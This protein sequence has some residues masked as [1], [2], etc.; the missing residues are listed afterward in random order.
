MDSGCFGVGV[1]V[2][3]GKGQVWS[4]RLPWNRWGWLKGWNKGQRERAAEM[5]L[6]SRGGKVG[7][8]TRKG[9]EDIL[10]G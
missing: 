3:R 8:G 4:L 10:C 9:H 1:L 7:E 6:P 2:P 5:G